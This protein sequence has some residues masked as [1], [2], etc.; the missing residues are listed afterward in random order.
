MK[1]GCFIKAA[2]ETTLSKKI[3]I[4]SGNIVLGGDISK[5]SSIQTEEGN[6]FIKWN[7][8]AIPDLFEKEVHGLAILKSTNTINI[9]EVIGFGSVE[10]QYYLIIE[11]IERGAPNSKFWDSFGQQLADLHRH[12]SP[13]YGLDIDNFIGRLPQ[14]N[15]Q[16]ENWVDFFVENRLDYQL[17]LGLT[18]QVLTAAFAS[19]IEKL[20]NKL[21]TLLP[22]EKPALLHGDLWS[23]NFLCDQKG[24]PCI[25]DPA[26]YY[27][28]REMEI[29]F[30]QLFGGF[31]SRF[32]HAYNEAF[33]LQKGFEER[34]DLYNIYPLL[35]HAN[36]FGGSY[37]S[38]VD[39]ILSRFI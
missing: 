29:A 10:N 27:G 18:N 6:F 2:L 21:P 9:P 8:H 17:Q 39:R 31:D 22:T 16:H 26:V 35:V 4:L 28:N 3:D 15:K 20:Y 25:Y 1:E 24:N 33:P 30:T 32:Y 34:K 11:L 5:A 12:S 37:A 36:L 23:G 7:T 19:K 13:N 14:I 38:S